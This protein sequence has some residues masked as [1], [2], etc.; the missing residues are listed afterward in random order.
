MLVGIF[1]DLAPYEPGLSFPAPRTLTCCYRKQ[2]IREN[3]Q[4]SLYSAQPS[5]DFEGLS[6]MVHACIPLSTLDLTDLTGMDACQA[7]HIS[8]HI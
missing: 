4:F 7:R 5:H 3:K 6:W 2:E 8:E 1:V